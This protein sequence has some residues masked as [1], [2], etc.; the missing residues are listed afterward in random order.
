MQKGRR[1][2]NKRVVLVAGMAMGMTLGIVGARAQEAGNTNQPPAVKMQTMCPVMEG[3]A[4]NKKVYTDYM[5]KRVYFC[6]G[7][8]P[9]VFAKDPKKYMQKMKEAGVTLEDAPKEGESP[10]ASV[11]AGK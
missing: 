5:G 6:C 1:K 9:K 2:M 10:K 8:C 7:N 4:V 3:N 11:P